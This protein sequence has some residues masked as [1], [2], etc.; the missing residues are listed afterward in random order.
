MAVLTVHSRW[1]EQNS[2]P[3]CLMGGGAPGGGLWLGGRG[4]HRGRS[5]VVERLGDGGWRE[6][7]WEADER[8][9]L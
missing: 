4:T 3:V 6:D 7:G 8:S 2:E 9:E 1:D 5:C